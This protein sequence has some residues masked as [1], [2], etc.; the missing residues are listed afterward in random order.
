MKP[1]SE[2]LQGDMRSPKNGSVPFGQLSFVCQT[3]DRQS[4]VRKTSIHESRSRTP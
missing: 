3:A 2:S 4:V 1:T